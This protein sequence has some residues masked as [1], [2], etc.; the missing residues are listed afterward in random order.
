M[1][2]YYVKMAKKNYMLKNNMLAIMF[3]EKKIIL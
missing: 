3:R 1:N 2:I